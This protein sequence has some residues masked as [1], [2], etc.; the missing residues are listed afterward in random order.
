MSRYQGHVAWPP[1]AKPAWI[2]CSLNS[3]Y[4]TKEKGKLSFLVYSLALAEVPLVK[5][6]VQHLE[7]GGHIIGG[8]ADVPSVKEGVQLKFPR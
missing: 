1:C 8:L 4:E 6:G 7:S 2:R 5:E 3:F